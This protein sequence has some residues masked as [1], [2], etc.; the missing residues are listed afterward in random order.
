M[1]ERT[2][3]GDEPTTGEPGSVHTIAGS[4]RLRIVLT[5]EVDADLGPELLEATKTA[6]MLGLPVEVDVRHVTFMDSSGVAFLAR[7]TTRSAYRVRLI[8]VP[9]T[10]RFLLE[11]TRIGELLDLVEED[12]GFDATLPDGSTPRGPERPEP[13]DIVA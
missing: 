5:G 1:R 12:A 10:V 7:L 9:P 2:A 6:E 8:H 4:E 11:V 13:P 3:E